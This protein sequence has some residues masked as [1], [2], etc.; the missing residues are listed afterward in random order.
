MYLYY[1]LHLFIG[2]HSGEVPPV[3]IPN[4]EVKLSSANGTAWA[5][6]WESRSPP[7]FFI[8]PSSGI[9]SD[10]GFLLLARN[11][12]GSTRF[13][14]DTAVITAPF[15]SRYDP[16]SC[17]A[18]ERGIH[19]YCPT[20]RFLV[21]G[22]LNSKKSRERSPAPMLLH[23]QLCGRVGRRRFYIQKPPSSPA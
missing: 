15:S 1:R 2:G 16:L 11:V 14:S 23:G 3:L 18:G 9:L 13:I 22:H 8:K 5:T 4:T 20:H 10:E 21:P 19:L 7:I 6:V 12:S 17:V